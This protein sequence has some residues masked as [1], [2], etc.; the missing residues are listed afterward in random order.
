[1]GLP[2]C[3][4]P[5]FLSSRSSPPSVS[6]F[7]WR[8]AIATSW[9]WLNRS[10]W[11]LAV[12]A[13]LD[14]YT[15]NSYTCRL[16]ILIE[17]QSRLNLTFVCRITHTCTTLSY[18]RLRYKS[19]ITNYREVWIEPVTATSEL[20]LSSNFISV[21]NRL[22]TTVNNFQHPIIFVFFFFFVGNIF[23]KNTH[24]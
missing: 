12:S 4:W 24:S 3:S 17:L 20:G 6:G 14:N 13:L 19:S 22:S 2:C 11:P 16:S 15:W 9:S 21:F 1:M 23:N 7:S 8:L 18:D 5:G 10:R